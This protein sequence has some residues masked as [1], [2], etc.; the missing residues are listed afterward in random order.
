M[1]QFDLVIQNGTV[2][3][4]A[5]TINCDIG[6]KD[7]KIVA[8][9]N[10]LTDAVEIVDAS[11]QYVLPGGIDAHVH[12]DEPPFYGVLLN[13]SF[14]TGTIAAACGGTTTIISFAQQEKGR[15]LRDSI[16]DYHA[17][18]S[19][20]AVIDYSFH[21]ILN[22]PDEKVTSEEI[23][24]LIED[25]YTSYKCFM[26]Y[27][28]ALDDGQ[29]LNTL[30]VAKRERAMVMIHAENEHCIRHMA[31]KLEEEGDTSL[32][33]FPKMAP[34]CVEREGTHRAIALSE[35]LDVPILLVHV[36]G[37]EAMDQIRWGQDRG[38]KIYGETCPQYLFLNEEIYNKE[39]WEAA[40]YLCAPPPRDRQNPD[41]LWRGIATGIFQVVSSDH[42]AFQFDSLSGK[43]A[44]GPEPHFRK[45]A[46]G[47]P[48]IEARLALIFSEG[49]LR[50]RIDINTFAAITATNPAKIYGL[51]PR[52]GTIAVGAD[53]DIT[54]WDPEIKHTI[55]HD[56]LHEEVDYTPYE[57]IE[58]K[59][60]PVKVFSRG[61]LIVADGDYVG[62]AGRGEFLRRDRANLK[63]PQGQAVRDI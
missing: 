61:N 20:K 21:V 24:A 55:S 63:P 57:G 25:G 48:G 19:G 18:A 36:S 52:K 58:V 16:N 37:R 4:A 32:D 27:A 35:L 11:G 7:G 17:K 56:L 60:W 41:A 30:E 53:A 1:T 13:D 6:I 34:M 14:E 59:G 43:K 51:Y 31:R 26:T 10:N 40:K 2:V 3:T 42:N 62:E 8:L 29:I 44:S 45:V 23:P 49:V 39:G 46:P 28:G 38:L 12:L 9:A 47:I 33:N 15:P 50:G 54:I 22:N 5:D